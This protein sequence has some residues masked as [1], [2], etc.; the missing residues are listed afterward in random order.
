[1]NTFPLVISSP[2]GDLWSGDAFLLTLRGVL[3]DLAIL[4]GHIPMVTPI[5]PCDI[6]IELPDESELHGAVEEGI[7]VVTAEKTTLLT[8]TFTW[9]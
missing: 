3:G 1:M 2:N 6:K 9:K 4:A 7:L 8:G 5:K